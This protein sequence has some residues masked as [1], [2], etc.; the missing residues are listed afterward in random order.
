MTNVWIGDTSQAPPASKW[1]LGSFDPMRMCPAPGC[2][3]KMN[4]M[5]SVVCGECRS[6]AQ[7][8][9]I[10]MEFRMMGL[11][12]IGEHEGHQQEKCWWNS[13]IIGGHEAT[14]SGDAW[15]S[16]Q[17]KFQWLPVEIGIPELCL[18]N[19][20]IFPNTFH[21]RS[22]SL[23]LIH[24][25]FILLYIFVYC[26][27]SSIA[28]QNLDLIVGFDGKFR[29]S[30][31]AQQVCLKHRFEATIGTRSWVWDAQDEELSWP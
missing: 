3:T 15:V 5:N 12:M 24:V 21:H 2:K 19:L 18:C 30:R 7:L 11:A 14:G 16:S 10:L 1:P 28:W 29:L 8:H 20:Y 22:Y 9:M 25:C 26:R 27:N 23:T 6:K 31:F 17:G 4:T 13:E